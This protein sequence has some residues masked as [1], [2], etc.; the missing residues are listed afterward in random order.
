MVLAFVLTPVQFFARRVSAPTNWLLAASAPALCALLQLWAALVAAGHTERIMASAAGSLGAAATTS[1][2]PYAL[3]IVSAFAYPAAFAAAVMVLLAL[4]VL[5]VDS[6]HSDRLAECA[7]LCFFT[8]VPCCLVGVVVALTWQPPALS[9]PAHGS[10][11]DVLDAVRQYRAALL[12]SP[13]VSTVRMLSY[14]SAIW[15]VAMLGTCLRVVSGLSR[16]QAVVVT[17]LS[18][19]VLAAAAFVPGWLT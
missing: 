9:L 7:G 18:L 16:R 3:A 6:G 17:F 12:D 1:S 19:V 14:Y 4:D 13:A 10:A 11:A 15:L 2:M 8:Q 5:L